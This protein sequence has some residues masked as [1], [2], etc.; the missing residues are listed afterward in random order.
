MR[1]LFTCLLLLLLQSPLLAIET[2]AESALSTSSEFGTGYSGGASGVTHSGF[3]FSPSRESRT[4]LVT[5]FA[6]LI[7]FNQNSSTPGPRESWRFVNDLGV[8]VNIGERMAL[9]ATVFFATDLEVWRYGVRPRLRV[10]L[11]SRSAFDLTAGLSHGSETHVET[12]S[13]TIGATVTYRDLIGVAVELDATQSGNQKYLD[14][15]GGVRAG[16]KVGIVATALS[17][18]AIGVLTL[19]YASAGFE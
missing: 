17:V 8:M 16:G 15:Y 3:T 14:L 12:S 13:G 10:W 18:A 2:I 1:R 11:T 6:L 9:G 5:E 19:M 7:G 4:F